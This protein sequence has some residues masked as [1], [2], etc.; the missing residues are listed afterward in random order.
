MEQRPECACSC[1]EVDR[2]TRCE[3]FDL[4]GTLELASRELADRLEHAESR[5][6]GGVIHLY[7]RLIDEMLQQVEHLHHLES[8]VRYDGLGGIECERTRED[9][10]APQ[11]QLLGL[12]QQG[13][14]PRDRS[15]KRL[16]A[17]KHDSRSAR[18]HADRVAESVE[19]LHRC[20]HATAR[21]CELD[22]QWYPVEL[23]A[24]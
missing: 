8:L 14:A 11:E 15:F 9:G 22:C 16:V 4:G 18:E 23:C 21:R 12:R 13:V 1:G 2:V 24:D 17:R 19:D 6:G 5:F 10:Q 7:Q 20:E 3:R